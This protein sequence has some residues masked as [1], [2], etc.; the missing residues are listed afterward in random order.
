MIPTMEGLVLN[1]YKYPFYK[2][3]CL[4][5]KSNDACVV[6]K[7]VANPFDDEVALLNLYTTFSILVRCMYFH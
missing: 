7:S 2:S 4:I 5:L 1:L 6:G 3:I